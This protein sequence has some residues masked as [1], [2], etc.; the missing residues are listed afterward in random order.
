MS[1]QRAAL[2]SVFLLV[3]TCALAGVTTTVVDVPTRSV[4]Q[5]FLYVHPDA[6]RANII[7]LFGG[8]GV[9]GILDDGSF[10]NPAGYCNPMVRV[11]QALADRGYAIAFVDAAS[12]G[13]VRNYPDVLAVINY[14]HAH[15]N[16]PTW[17]IGGDLSTKGTANIVGQLPVSYPAGVIFHAPDS[18]MLRYW[19]SSSDHR[20]SSGTD[21]IRSNSALRYTPV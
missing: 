1:S 13:R 15:D 11:R 12:D 20:L 18:W 2:V 6:P 9:L 10:S 14:L 3:S 4:I 21:W 17:V 7:D 16:V 8:T 19:R 5:R